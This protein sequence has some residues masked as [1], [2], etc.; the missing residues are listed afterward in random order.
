METM[1]QQP[2]EKVSRP[3]VK[4]LVEL[5]QDRS[6]RGRAA[7]AELRRE[8]TN[9]PECGER[10]LRHVV[11]YFPR[12]DSSWR[13]ERSEDA[14][15]LVA[16]LFALSRSERDGHLN[17]G[18]VMRETANRRKADDAIEARFLR[19]LG[20]RDETEIAT[21]LRHAVQMATNEGVAI[22]WSQLLN[23]L[24][25]VLSREEYTRKKVLRDWSRS[26]WQAESEDAVDTKT[27]AN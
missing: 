9:W 5:A 2:E 17:M 18:G 12:E 20:A 10:A 11:P 23:D 27:E 25:H 22:G 21:H 6:G 24:P 8:A 19:L 15:L 1:K 7:L 14:M 16:T 4:R 3:L 26:F 13:T